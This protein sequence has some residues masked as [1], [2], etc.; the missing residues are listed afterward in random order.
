WLPRHHS[1]SAYFRSTI[2]V[3]GPGAH[4]G[5]RRA[6]RDVPFGRCHTVNQSPN[7]VRV[8]TRPVP[9]SRHIYTSIRIFTPRWPFAR[10]RD[11]P[12]LVFPRWGCTS[13]IIAALPSVA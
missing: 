8:L 3:R 10:G 6:S 4:G 2:P 13:G 5:T 12:T 1:A 11:V 9:Q 7:G